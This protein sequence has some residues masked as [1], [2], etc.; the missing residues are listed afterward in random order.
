MKFD[1]KKMTGMAML[2][3]LSICSLY[4]VRFWIFPTLQFLE[5][6][7]A[8]VFIFLG[9]FMYGPVSGLIM[10]LVVSLYQAFFMG[11]NAFTGALMH[12]LATGSFCLTS[13]LIYYKN[14]SLKGALISLI[15]GFFVWIT[16][17]ILADLIIIPP[18]MGVPLGAVIASLPLILAFNAIKA[19]VN[20][21]LTFLLYKRVHKLF[22]LIGIANR[23]VKATIDAKIDK[24][25][26]IENAIK[27]QETITSETYS[28]SS[29]KETEI[30]AKN[31]ASKLKPGDTVLL[32][33]DLGAGKTVFARGIARGLGID[34]D[35]L[36]PTFNI[37]K[38]YDGGRFCH[39]DMYRIEDEEE[40]L[41]LGF[42][43]YFGG[44]AICVVEWNRMPKIQGRVFEVEITNIDGNNKRK[45][46]ISCGVKS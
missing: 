29:A 34:E 36:S 40:L 31:F 9:T 19:G 44:E 5:Y 16:V 23:M 35:I 43:E 24:I 18:F 33:G 15:T 10:T 26:R 6:D 37:L 4:L 20:S 11:G 27:E 46:Q 8:D 14:R 22:G 12:F 30:L 32:N 45:I 21:I 25:E 17:M 7:L 28:T 41:N 42:E 39:F 13:G 38:E 2:S 1:T 3:A